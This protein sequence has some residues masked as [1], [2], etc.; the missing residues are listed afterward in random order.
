MSIDV[1]TVIVPSSNCTVDIVVGFDVSRSHGETLRRH[2]PRLEE[3]VRYISTVNDVC[4]GAPV[5]INMAFYAVDV[6]RRSLIDTNFE[7]YNEDLVRKVLNTSCS[8]PTLF[9]SS[10]LDVFRDVFKADSEAKVKVRANP[11]CVFVFLS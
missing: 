7:S 4:C 10:T 5:R 3:I 2:V 9:N 8:R 11:G 1:P 6:D